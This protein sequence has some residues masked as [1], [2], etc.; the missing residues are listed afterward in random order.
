MSHTSSAHLNQE[1]AQWVERNKD[2]LIAEA[3]ELIRMPSENR[4][5][6]GG[7]LPVQ[8][9]LHEALAL[10][11]MESELYELSDVEGLEQHPYYWPGRDYTDRPNLY[12]VK[13]GAGGGKSLMFSV[14]ADVVVGIAGEVQP[15]EPEIRDG[16]LYGRGSNDMKG[17]IAAILS[18][19]RYLQ[20]NKIILKGDLSL[21]S[22]VDEEMGGANGTLAGRIRGFQ[23]DAV[24]IP[25]PTNLRVCPAHLGGVT[26][27]IRIKGK[28]GM[29]FGGEELINPAYGMAYII[30][31]IE[32][33][34]E[35]YRGKIAH[36]TPSGH[37]LTPNVV[38]SYAK[39]GEF[40][41]GMGDGIPSVCLLEVWVESIPG[42]T[43]ADL[44]HSFQERIQTLILTIPVLQ[45]LE[46]TWEQVTRFLSGSRAKTELTPLLTSLVRDQC[47]LP[48]ED[49][50]APFACDAFLFNLYSPSPAVILG[51][52]GE[53]AHAA[54]EFVDI[55]SLEQLTKVYI[56]AIMQ[57]CEYKE[58]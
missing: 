48:E 23:A 42:E 49:W 12:A 20:E 1:I 8:R 18:A 33:F 15:F 22:V 41:P 21:E 17:G 55:A 52:S 31:E 53:N 43:L 24:I 37:I 45:S 19:F 35:G 9:Y 4:P 38:L 27:R 2:K 46:V 50:M 40:E 39:A 29:G 3:I 26:W 51:P 10:L 58:E 44:E 47:G 6:V 14:H 32:A 16:R 5:P 13:R 56:A 57:W 11:G 25:E 28:G 30:R 7:E 54:D 34:H 36:S